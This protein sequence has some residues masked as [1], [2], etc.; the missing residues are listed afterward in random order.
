VTPI[1]GLGLLLV[2]LSRRLLLL[3][4]VYTNKVFFAKIMQI[5]HLPALVA[6]SN[7]VF[8]TTLN[9]AKSTLGQ[10]LYLHWLPFAIRHQQNHRYLKKSRLLKFCCV[11]TTSTAFLAY[12]LLWPLT[13]LMRQTREVVCVINQS[14]FLR[15]LCTKLK[16]V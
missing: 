5:W 14:I 6:V 12:F 11:P 2:S 10:C 8:K 16:V 9:G 1:Q 4:F 13:V 7:V 3:R 15:Y